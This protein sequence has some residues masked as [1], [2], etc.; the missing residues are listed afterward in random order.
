MRQLLVLILIVLEIWVPAVVLSWPVIRVR[1]VYADDFMD[2][3]RQGQALGSILLPSPE[4]MATQDA[5]GNLTINHGG[6]AT[7]VRPQ[8]LFPDMS[9]TANPNTGNLAGSEAGIQ[10]QTNSQIDEMGSSTSYTGQAYQ[11][12]QGSM[13]RARTNLSND[14]IWAQT[15]AAMQQALED[16]PANCHTEF[17]QQQA[18]STVH[19][20]DYR[21][22][23]KIAFPAGGVCRLYH[24][25]SLEI[26]SEIGLYVAADTDDAAYFFIDHTVPSLDECRAVTHGVANCTFTTEAVDYNAACGEVSEGV[27]KIFR[28]NENSVFSHVVQEPTCENYLYSITAVHATPGCHCWERREGSF[29]WK[30]VN[31][32][33]RGWTAD[34][35]CEVLLTNPDGDAFLR[36]VSYE[37]TEGPCADEAQ[38]SGVY[39][40]QADMYSNNPLASKGISNLAKV[41]TVNV[42]S[43]NAGQMDCW[44]D[45]QGVE[46]CPENLGDRNNTCGEYENN[47]GCAYV[48]QECIE[49][50]RDPES[51][52]CY[53]W[54]VIYDCG[55]DV[56][57]GSTSTSIAMVCDGV[58]RCMGTECVSGQFDAN[59]TD[60]AQAVAYLQATQYASTDLDC[61][62][63]NEGGCT[64]FPGDSYECK[65]ALGGWVDCC[66]QPE[67][68]SLKEYIILLGATK[69]FISM[70]WSIANF[71]PL[72]TNPFSGAYSALSSAWDYTSDMM[73]S[74]WDSL[75]GNTTIASSVSSGQGIT[76]YLMGAAYDWTTEH[77]P[78]LAANIFVE[79]GIEV[80]FAPWIQQFIPYIQVVMW[81]YT[82]YNILNIL[83][84]I[85]WACEEK[86]FE[87]GAK[88]QLKVCHYVG[89]Y[90]KTT[91]LGMC[92]E[93]RDSYCCFNS[94]LSRILQEQIRVQTDHSWGSAEGPDCAGLRMN[95]LAQVNWDQIDLS[96]WLGL[97]AIAG[98]SP[99]QR[100]LSLSGLTGS[101]SQFN[102]DGQAGRLDAATRTTERLGTYQ[103]QT[104]QD[105]EQLRIERGLNMWGQN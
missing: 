47:P 69:K 82:L 84:H 73:T 40:K 86:E 55:A 77:F 14:P 48:R 101:G 28:A 9:N 30:A 76:Q 71:G 52:Q 70:E 87:L 63:A 66:V 92:I 26:K 102:F 60:F 17:V 49:G 94:P 41:A 89:S 53:A 37:C 18:T 79:E 2:A 23:E 19:V 51:G 32:I 7:V 61:S 11:T 10:S 36:P 15:D 62:D 34:P 46:H 4:G 75:T 85:I 29:L 13:H 1:L 35:G 42:E 43:F 78:N 44:T 93:K 5:D 27:V 83:V 68:V 58:V 6:N 16:N 91:V 59:N 25:Y 90:C 100:E 8:D 57:T 39:V 81:M 97:L 99:D 65:K 33:D 56:Q 31:L 45:P 64:V 72:S 38:I 95:E 50:A 3:A 74:A 80:N 103:E 98:E 88:R 96:E 105:L 22:C 20:P 12:L 24:D 67:G 54:T 21:T 104:G